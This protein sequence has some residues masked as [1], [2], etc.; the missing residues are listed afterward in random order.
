[1]ASG[2]ISFIQFVCKGKQRTPA[3]T[4]VISKT[5][6]PFNGNAISSF[7]TSAIPLRQALQRPVGVPLDCNNT[8]EA[9]GSNRAHIE[10]SILDS[11]ERLRELEL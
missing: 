1:M 7:A 5:L 9:R 11:E 8:R 10:G 4:R 3:R 6:M 2:L